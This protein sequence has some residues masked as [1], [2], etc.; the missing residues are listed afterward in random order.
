[1]LLLVLRLLSVVVLGTAFSVLLIL[2]PAVGYA[3][4]LPAVG[5]ARLLPAV[6]YAI[7][8]AVGYAILPAV[9]FV[10]L[11]SSSSFLQIFDVLLAVLVPLLLYF[12]LLTTDSLAVVPS[13]LLFQ[14]HIVVG[15]DSLDR[16]WLPPTSQ[17]SVA[18][19]VIDGSR[20]V[21]SIH[22]KAV[23]QQR[24][25]HLCS[26]VCSARVV[27][28]AARRYS[29][30]PLCDALDCVHHHNEGIH[31]GLLSLRG[32]LVRPTL[33]RVPRSSCLF[34]PSRLLMTRC[35]LACTWAAVPTLLNFSLRYVPFAE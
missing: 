32:L 8:P 3:R 10:F 22:A 21:P 11:G 34:F 17:L 14:S 15:Y 1:M 4:L 18:P 23:L 27:A 7:L 30:M 16:L 20:L 35:V 28:S 9:R 31:R 25:L 13:V 33:L 12:V 2:L 29:P 19:F 26:R 6:G 5:Y 24:V